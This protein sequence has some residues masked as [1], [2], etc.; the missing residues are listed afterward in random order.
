ML[1]FWAG[2]ALG[3]AA[4]GAGVVIWAVIADGSARD[5]DRV[6]DWTEYAAMVKRQRQAREGRGVGASGRRGG[7]DQRDG[8]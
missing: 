5:E 8:G 3:V 2:Y 6:G 1:A 7:E 4:G